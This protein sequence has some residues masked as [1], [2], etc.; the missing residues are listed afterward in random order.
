MPGKRLLPTGKDN[1]LCK[2]CK[3][4]ITL[5]ADITACYYVI[6]TKQRRNC[7]IGLCDKYEKGKR[8]EKNGIDLRG[9]IGW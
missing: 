2:S 5:K 6:D 3:Y 1:K 9:D 4:S 8:K 7:P